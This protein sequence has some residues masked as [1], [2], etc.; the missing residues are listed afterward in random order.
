M[1]SNHR[2]QIIGKL[3]LT[4][5]SITILSA[6]S[7][8]AIAIERYTRTQEIN[9]AKEHDDTI[10]L[11][12]ESTITISEGGSLT[13]T[14]PQ[15]EDAST[16]RKEILIGTRGY[17][18]T[19]LEIQGG[20]V[21]SGSNIKLGIGRDAV[22]KVNVKNGQTLTASEALIVGG[23][24]GGTGEIN[25]IGDGS[26][27]AAKH[28]NLGQEYHSTGS[29][30]AD[31]HAIVMATESL[32]VGANGI[33]KLDIKNKSE[34]YSNVLNINHGSVNIDNASLEIKDINKTGDNIAKF[35]LTDS[36]LTL[37]EKPTSTLFDGF[38]D[39]DTATLKNLTMISDHDATLNAVAKLTGET[40]HKKGT[41]TLNIDAN[42]KQWTGNT[43]LESGT[44]KING[45][46]TLGANQT[47]HLSL[48]DKNDYGK[49]N[50]TGTADISNGGLTIKAQDAIK[51]LLDGSIR[52]N[53]HIW[54]NIIKAKTLKGQFA[55]E[56]FNVLDSQGNQIANPLLTL[57]YQDNAVH[58]TTK[59]KSPEVNL[60]KMAKDQ[61]QYSLLNLTA[62]LDD[63][64]ADPKNPLGNALNLY[65]QNLQNQGNINQINQTIVQMQPLIGGKVNH[66][67][68]QSHQYAPLA[69]YHTQKG[70][71]L[72]AN[73]INNKSSQ[74]SPTNGLLGFDKTDKGVMTGIDGNLGQIKLGLILGKISSQ[75]DSKKSPAYHD[76]KAKTTQAIFYTGFHDGNTQLHGYVGGG[77]SDIDATRKLTLSNTTISTNSKYQTH[78]KQAGIGVSYQI[79][80][81]DKHLTPFATLD[82]VQINSPAYQETGNNILNLHVDDNSHKSLYS[83]FGMR[84]KQPLNHVI[85]I[86]GMLAGM[87]EN[88]SRRTQTT[89]AFGVN[90]NKKFSISGDDIAQTS[91]LAGMGLGMNLTPNIN[92]TLD[93]Q[94]QWQKSHKRQHMGI[95]LQSQF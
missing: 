76:L 32:N 84:F 64:L 19:T 35:T 38:K 85:F 86:D 60:S 59:L 5:L 66:L 72:W 61:K 40:F 73:I 75:I 33:G 28:I 36:A 82:Y 57:D 45:D 56:A 37:S 58:L 9:T 78:S 93:Y 53:T 25:I 17:D 11:S 2:I 55:K 68:A 48:N 31:D 74:D 10:L 18:T 83:M 29:I 52:N 27:V 22:G 80:T 89:T 50:V 16:T 79:G 95:S 12:N 8:Q 54:Q 1:P 23:I 24:G 49:L 92:I 14:L 87:L 41:G 34:L 71:H 88:G 63:F 90:P 47:L 13:L 62:T 39:S 81:K 43:T 91:L 51:Q 3:S 46:Y 4:T 26:N 42:S 77:K 21:V 44:L 7:T 20:G 70:S 94:G 15:G 30:V 67:I 65:A 69:L 6:L